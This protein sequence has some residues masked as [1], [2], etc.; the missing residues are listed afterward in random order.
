MRKRIPALLIFI[1]FLVSFAV[2]LN[3]LSNDF[4]YDDSDQVLEN[5]WIRDVK[6]LPDIF[7]KSVWSF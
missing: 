2:Y 3:A 6:Y 7:S 1:I 5:H 4:V